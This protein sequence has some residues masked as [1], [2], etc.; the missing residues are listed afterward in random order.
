MISVK[1]DLWPQMVSTESRCLFLSLNVFIA[2]FPGKQKMT[3]LGTSASLK[4]CAGEGENQI[5]VFIFPIKFFTYSF[6]VYK[7]ILFLT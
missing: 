5:F 2:E 4:G 7:L 6:T 3:T 1:T